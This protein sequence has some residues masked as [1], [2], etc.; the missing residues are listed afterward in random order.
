VDDLTLAENR[1]YPQPSKLQGTLDEFTEWTNKNKL[2]L[3][4]TKCQAIQVC[5]KREIP[6]PTELKIDGVPLNIVPE[7]K[8]L[9][10]WL[11]KDLKWEKHLDEMTK[12]ANQKL[13]MLKLLKKLGS[14]TPN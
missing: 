13:Y 5:F 3:N 6:N 11:Q 12:K 1:P 8:I 2:S 14:M 7:A 10:V 4:P 9:G